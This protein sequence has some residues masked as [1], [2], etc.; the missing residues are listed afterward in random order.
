MRKSK[1][2]LIGQIYS[3]GRSLNPGFALSDGRRL[4][5]QTETSFFRITVLAPSVSGKS[6]VDAP[7]E[8]IIEE[9][10][11]LATSLHETRP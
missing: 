6:S 7:E 10:V 9:C 5:V 3:N 1:T 11:V 2:P 4:S 8:P